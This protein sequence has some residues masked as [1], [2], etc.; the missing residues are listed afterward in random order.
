MTKYPLSE[1][2]LATAKEILAERR[3]I[4]DLMHQLVERATQHKVRQAAFYE[5][6][7]EKRGLRLLD[8]TQ[9][10]VNLDDGVLHVQTQLL[11]RPPEG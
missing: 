1:E 11:V 6:C 8:G 5:H 9:V 3:A 4:E 7:L 10:G 2:E